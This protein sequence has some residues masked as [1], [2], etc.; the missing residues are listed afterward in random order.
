[1]NVVRNRKI[2]V[3]SYSVRDDLSF[4]I[5]Y[6]T[7]ISKLPGNGGI[8]WMQ[9]ADLNR[10]ETEASILAERMSEKHSLY[11]TGFTGAKIVANGHVNY[12]N[13][14]LLFENIASVLNEYNG[15]IYTGCDINTTNDDMYALSERTRF[16]LSSL[17]NAN[18]DTSVATAYGV[19]AS[20]KAVLEMEDL[21]NKTP[22]ISIH[23]LGK[24]GKIVAELAIEDNYHVMGYDKDAGK[25]DIDGLSTITDEECF[26]CPCEILVLCSVSGVLT[27]QKAKI[28]NTKWVV[29]SANA[30]LS[31]PS[32]E[33]IMQ[34]RKVRYLP[35]VVSNAGAVICDSLEHY[36][37]DIHADLSQNMVNEYV[38]QIIRS[39]TLAIIS[40][41]VI[42]QASMAAVVKSEFDLDCDFIKNCQAA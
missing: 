19:Y 29:S 40:K 3:E 4:S 15:S 39:K 22:R 17:N 37:P 18:V 16:I 20:L 38:S 34:A 2:V 25:C 23:G 13:R 6:D 7:L 35:D 1:M 42:L 10:Q 14:K 24:V 28:V 5:A 41:S 9:Y 21:G 26:H 36:Y 32:V 33:S 27:E 12:T 30:P 8:R 11:K 31:S